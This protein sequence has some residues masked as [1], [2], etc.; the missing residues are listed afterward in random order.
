MFK[1]E[2]Y[3]IVF[4]ME[5]ELQKS[6]DLKPYQYNK[7]NIKYA[8][9]KKEH[10]EELCNFAGRSLYCCLFMGNYFYN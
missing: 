5:I 10:S 8:N 4:I 7:N 2:F 3:V 1:G 9:E 6:K